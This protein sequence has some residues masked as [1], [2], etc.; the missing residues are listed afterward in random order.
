MESISTE[1][2]LTTKAV[3]ASF[4]LVPAIIFAGLFLDAIHPI[5]WQD[6]TLLDSQGVNLK[7]EN[8]A[9][10][11]TPSVYFYCRFLRSQTQLTLTK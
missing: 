6:A 5:I 2:L 9:I 1:T 7:N 3:A 10:Q 11:C 4:P 8:P